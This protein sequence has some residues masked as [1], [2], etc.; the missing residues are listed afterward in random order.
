LLS[1][2]FTLRMSFASLLLLS[3]TACE[4]Y[5]FTVNDTVVYT[6][7]GLFRDFQ[8]ADSALQA[9]LQQ[10][11][12]DQRISRADQLSS[13]NCSH[14]GIASL[15]GLDTFT[16]LIGLKLSTNKIRNLM[17]VARLEQLQK[18]Q[19]D[20]NRVV[21]PVPLYSLTKL[22]TLDLGG[23]GTLQCPQR[24]AWPEIQQLILPDHCIIDPNSAAED[25]PPQ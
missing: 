13:L 23:N 15:D 17:P 4:N 19:L 12:N 14:A 6:P 2:R 9:C 20:D 24:S 18:L 25:S 10:A 3:L 11:I 5:D 1:L 16:G 8:V 22:R 7:A 21:D